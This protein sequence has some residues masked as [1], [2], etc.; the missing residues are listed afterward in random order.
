MDRSTW[1]R[2][3][4]L[5]AVAPL[6]IAGTRQLVGTCTL[7]TNGAVT[8]GFTSSELLRLV[9]GQ[10]L[11]IA[12]KLDGSQ[13]VPIG[14]WGPGA[15]TGLGLVTL[16]TPFVVDPR[17]DVMPIAIGS[18][19]ATV[20][21][22]GSPSVL[23]AM[24][25]SPTGYA[26]VV[27]PVHLDAVGDGSDVVARLATPLDQADASVAVEGTPV[28]AWFPPD[29]ALGRKSEV[30][31]LA[32]AYAYR[33]QLYAPRGRPAIAELVGLDDLAR[34]LPYGSPEQE[35]ELG[36]VAGEIRDSELGPALDDD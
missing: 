18:V 29:P 26:R 14:S 34:A 25:P 13:L 23:V 5:R 30:L 16:A 32:L 12:T 6:V 19:C 15:Y 35:P 3:K 1:D 17:L 28:F 2:A 21:N 11:A 24:M 36:Q 8:V 4:E 27:V 7:V 9:A 31:A 20:D 33:Q 10:Q 22:R